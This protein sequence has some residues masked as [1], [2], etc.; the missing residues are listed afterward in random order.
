MVLNDNKSRY[1][2]SPGADDDRV[3]FTELRFIESPLP[4]RRRP[5]PL[6]IGLDPVFRIV[7]IKR[8][9]ASVHWPAR[10]RRSS[11]F[12]GRLLG[13][14]DVRR[15]IASLAQELLNVAW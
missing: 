11:G 4:V 14:L 9:G 2:P 6:D 3:A 8:L 15:K 1:S 7:G 12:F 10:T 5:D 13:R